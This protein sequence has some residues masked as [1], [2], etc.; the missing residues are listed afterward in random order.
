MNLSLKPRWSAIHGMTLIGLCF[1]TGCG[2]P[3]D[4]G[5]KLQTGDKRIVL[6]TVTSVETV[7]VPGRTA[8]KHAGEEMAYLFEVSDVSP[9]AGATT[10]VT[11]TSSDRTEG[12]SFSV[13]G[14]SGFMPVDEQTALLEKLTRHMKGESFTARLNSRGEVASVSG[15][16]KVLV[17]AMAKYVAEKP[18]ERSLFDRVR[19]K[20]EQ[21]KALNDEVRA[22]LDELLHIYPESPVRMGGTWIQETSYDSDIT[23]DIKR[24]FEVKRLEEDTITIESNGEVQSVTFNGRGDSSGSILGPGFDGKE[25]GTISLDRA[26]GWIKKAEFTLQGSTMINYSSK[27][28]GA[29]EIKFA[30]EN[31]TIVESFPAN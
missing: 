5:L 12:R 17:G 6:V 25:V 16:E 18:T 24:S 3:L 8:E 31:K 23:L 22:D 15:M 21:M 10:K 20:D 4:L 28:A 2:R 14:A 27:N 26:T 19:G 30:I 7:T 29:K 11:I 13:E 1:V 9:D